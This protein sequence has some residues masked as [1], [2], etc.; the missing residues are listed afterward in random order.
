MASGPCSCV[1]GD[2]VAIT[3]S[4]GVF[5]V[6]GTVLSISFTHLIQYL[7]WS[8]ELDIVIFSFYKRKSGLSR[9]RATFKATY[10]IG[11]LLASGP[12]SVRSSAHPCSKN[13]ALNPNLT[14]FKCHIL[15]SYL[16]LPH[17]GFK[18]Q[19]SLVGIILPVAPLSPRET[20]ALALK[21]RKP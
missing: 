7:H 13:L 21:F 14:A 5:R 20:T 16:V 2:L 3:D 9:A 18:L 1:F 4:Y 12:I 19:R 11:W 10:T 17:C 8:F 15:N 6:P